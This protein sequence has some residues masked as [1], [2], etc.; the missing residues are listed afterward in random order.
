[1]QDQSTGRIRLP[2]PKEGEKVG[3]GVKRKI[4]KKEQKEEAKKEK[5][6]KERE[7]KKHK[8]PDEPPK[9]DDDDSIVPAPARPLTPKL[10]FDDP[11]VHPPDEPPTGG[12][13]YPTVPAPDQ[14]LTLIIDEPVVPPQDE[15]PPP[16]PRQNRYPD[17]PPPLPPFPQFYQKTSLKEMKKRH[18]KIKKEIK[19]LEKQLIKLHLEKDRLTLCADFFETDPE[20]FMKQI[21]SDSP[22]SDDEERKDRSPTPPPVPR[23]PPEI[24]FIQALGCALYS[25]IPSHQRQW[26]SSHSG[27][28]RNHHF[29][30]DSDRRRERPDDPLLPEPFTLFG[31]SRGSTFEMPIPEHRSPSPTR[32]RMPSPKRENTGHR[33]GCCC[34]ECVHG[35]PYPHPLGQ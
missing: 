34:Y 6:K 2:P 17:Q 9:R 21:E 15:P 7:K 28:A 13:H 14:Q 23:K 10:E 22:S 33:G 11:F 1:M 5:K 32:P 18:K 29:G 24:S 16:P 3:V 12:Y 8:P 30:E 4:M 19:N 25:A 31:S 26:R 27:S 35:R 20:D